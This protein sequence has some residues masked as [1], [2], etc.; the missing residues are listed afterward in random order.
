MVLQ[1]IIATTGMSNDDLERRIADKQ[2]ELS[3]LVSREGAAYI[4]AKEL[5]LELFEK[6]KRRLEIKNVLPGLKN[7]TLTARVLRIFEPRQFERE[8]QQSAVANVIIGDGTG[9]LRLSLWDQQIE[10][11]KQMQPGLAIEI[12]GAYTKDDSR[13]GTEIRLSKRGGIRVL[14]Q[15]DLPAIDTIRAAAQETPV[16]A[17]LSALKEGGLFEV[18]AAVVQ[19]FDSNM[20]Y[21]VCPTCGARVHKETVKEGPRQYM[22]FKCAQHGEIQP[23]QSMVIS[24][25]IDD[26]SANIRAVWFR[27]AALNLIG[28]PIE[29]AVER[30]DGLLESLD[31]LGREYV[32]VGRVKKNKM[33]NRIEFIV[34]AVKPVE[35]KAEAE[36]LI[37]AVQ[38]GC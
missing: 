25:V 10:H 38:R 16:R 19:L 31:V 6:T 27:D 7:V 23:S 22:V 8:G 33:F 26:G 4:I 30:K 32:M 15:S 24:G 17:D 20:F 18:R 36:A 2:R 1:R 29:T 5:G 34:N 21:E 14:A 9:S 35:L 12:F 28:M 11:L 13:G 3:D 37:N